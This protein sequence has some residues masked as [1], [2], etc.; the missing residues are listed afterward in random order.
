MVQR[1]K[2]FRMP[3]LAAVAAA[4]L[5]AIAG[6]AS[7]ASDSYTFAGL[8]WGS[9]PEAASNV[10]KS[11]GFKIGPVVKG[12]QRELVENGAWGEFVTID[13]GKRLLATG[14]VAGQ[15][16][17]VHLVF[18][19][20]D[21]LDRVIVSLPEW[22]GTVPHAEQLTKAAATLTSQLEKQYG[23]T[24]EKRDF[25]GWPDTARWQPAQDGS[26]MEMLIRGT[27]GMMFYPGYRTGVRLDLWNDAINGGGSAPA[28]D[29]R[30]QTVDVSTPADKPVYQPL[31]L[32]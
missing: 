10:L 14:T 13:R 27:R 17:D 32:Q 11:K 15:K 25:F 24:A 21:R 31:S 2:T 3:G 28:F 26:R 18:G 23:A 22:N 5:T 30:P 16:A 12:P 9:S 7:A 29:N 20:N 4:A 1:R 6:S 19:S 8:E